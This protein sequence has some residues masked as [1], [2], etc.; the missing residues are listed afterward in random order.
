MLLAVNIGNSNIRFGVFKPEEEIISWTINTKPY[1]TEDECFAKFNSMYRP[2]GLKKEDITGIVIGSVVPPMTASVVNS[3]ERIHQITPKVVDRNTPSEVKHQSKQMGTDLY[4][5]A[6]AAHGL[7]E[8][9]K[10][11][12]DFG[13]AL[14]FTA[15]DENGQSL[16][17]VIAP[18]INTALKSLIGE[19]AQLPEIEMKAPEKV[20]GFDTVSCMQSG[21]VYGFLSFVEGM[22]DRINEEVNA[23]CFVVATG[24]MSYVYAPLTKKIDRQDALHTIKGLKILYNQ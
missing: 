13:T 15:L 5:N 1:R 8:G 4:A 10:I 21:M 22:I 7:Y 9:K 3:L 17:V 6:V 16:G 23:K 24:G 14:T 12:I 18:G 20:L 11:V 2:F 19:T